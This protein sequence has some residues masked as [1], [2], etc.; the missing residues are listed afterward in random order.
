MP[1]E[2]DTPTP[3]KPPRLM[4][5]QTV[6]LVMLAGA[7]AAA[8]GLARL[9]PSQDEESVL[10]YANA[11]ACIAGTRRTEEDCRSEYLTARAA[12]P[13]VAPRYATVTDCEAHHG[14]SHCLPGDGVA[15]SAAGRFVPR[16]AG[17]VIGRRIDQNLPPQPIFD[18]APNSEASHSG[19]AGHSGGA[20][21]CTSWG[22]RITTS[23]GGAS[24]SARVAS[25]AVRKV[26]YGGFGS[27]GRS[28]SS[29]GWSSHGS[30]G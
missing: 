25:S 27:T 16:M 29:H 21:Y 24:S 19:S 13:E 26:A 1:S 28:F 7:G 30:G 22:G 20:G 9:D 17:Y 18:H 11:D 12:Y 2:A 6:T 14:P 15:V 10:V 4:R 23:S 8:F 5:S 3:V